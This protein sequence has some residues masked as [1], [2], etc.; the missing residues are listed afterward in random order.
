[1]T[2]FIGVP[3]RRQNLSVPLPDVYKAFEQRGPGTEK[4]ILRY[5]T[6]IGLKMYPPRIRRGES[7]VSPVIGV[8]L[9]VAITIV[10][11]AV[12]FAWVQSIVDQPKAALPTVELATIKT[13]DGDYRILIQRIQDNGA[14]T[15]VASF[16]YLLLDD[17]DIPTSHAGS[18]RDIY[19]LDMDVDSDLDG[20]KDFDVAFHEGGLEPNGE[21]DANDQFFIRSSRNDGPAR[22][23]YAFR[24]MYQ[25]STPVIVKT[26]RIIG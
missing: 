16:S 20:I 23:G 2:T 18:I 10:L 15:S 14:S 22:P 11:A 1:M 5:V 25:A 13:S 7:A 4:N 19:N 6:Y 3:G 26:A 12:V 24:L 8:I 17:N 21:L 9:M